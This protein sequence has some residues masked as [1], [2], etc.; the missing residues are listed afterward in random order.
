MADEYWE[1]LGDPY[2]ATRILEVSELP[3]T[4]VKSQLWLDINATVTQIVLP[5]NLEDDEDL[6]DHY[7]VMMLEDDQMG[8]LIESF[9][10]HDKLEIDLLMD[11]SSTSSILATI[12]NELSKSIHVSS[13]DLQCIA[14]T[15]VHDASR[16]LVGRVCSSGSRGLRVHMEACIK[17]DAI[18]DDVAADDEVQPAFVPASKSAIEKLERVRV[19]TAGVCCSVCI[20]EIAVGSEGRGLPCSHIYHEAC[21]VEWLEKSHFCP[22]CRFS[23]PA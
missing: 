3:E 9:D 10:Y 6:E 16:C 13:Q 23:L 20:A 21:I 22:L 19:E 7:K 12:S 18:V 17:I 11:D 2:Y 8:Q 5:S 14:A 1:V 4:A 15:I